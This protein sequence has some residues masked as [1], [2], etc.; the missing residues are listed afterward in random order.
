MI[1][2]VQHRERMSSSLPA[3]GTLL[4][5]YVQLE[6]P[7]NAPSASTFRCR[8]TYLDGTSTQL[9]MPDGSQAYAVDDPHFLG[10]VIVAN[11][12][13]PVRIVFYNL[14]PTGAEGD[15]FLPVDSTIMGSGMGPMDMMPRWMMGT[16]MDMVRNPMCGE[17]PERPCG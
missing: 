4:R 8:T 2:V 13:K 5:E 1:A 17:V 12:N 3:T 15:L 10:P 7:E 6:T 9:L 11:K 14:L 16:V